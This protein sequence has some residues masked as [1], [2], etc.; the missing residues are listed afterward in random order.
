MSLSQALNKSQS[1]TNLIVDSLI[2][3]GVPI[4]G[5]G[6]QQVVGSPYINVITFGG[7]AT[8]DNGGVIEV[9]GGS[10]IVIGGSAQTPEINNIGVIGVNGC[11]GGVFLTSSDNTITITPDLV[12]NTVDITVPTPPIVVD[13]LNGCTGTVS[14]VSSDNT[15]TITP[16][17]GNG[18]IDLAAV[19][20]VVVDSLQ[21]LNG[22]VLLSSPLSTIAIGTNGQTIELDANFPAPITLTAGTGITVGT[23]PNYTVT[24]TA[25]AIVYTAGT[26]I[27][28]DVNNVIT[29]TAPGGG[30]SSYY[31]YRADNGAIPTT[32]HISWSNFGTQTSSTYIR[33]NHI[34]Q[35]GIDIDVFLNLIQQGNQLI[36][37][38]A[39]ASANYQTWL[40]S[41]TPIP[42]TGSGYAQFPITLVASGGSSNFANNHQLILAVVSSAPTP[43]IV[44]D[45]LNGCTG[46]VSLVS[47]DNTIT[48]TPDVLTSTVDL[49]F[50]PV[51]QATYYKSTAQTLTSGTTDI[52]FDLTGSWNNVGGCITH[53]DGTT[54]FTVARTGVYQLGFN[55][56]VNIGTGTWVA[57]SNKGI[58]IDITRSPITEVAVIRNTAAM[59]INSYTQSVSGTYY[60]VVGDVIN[61][62]LTNTFTNVGITPTQTL[63]FV[64][65]FDLNTF[66]SWTLIT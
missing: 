33:V 64:N 19:Q 8:I 50:P 26:G 66:F 61:L 46:T 57:G 18:T 40:V 62:S 23:A 59:A 13:S 55:A 30:S 12:A 39:N 1:G 24:N 41:G 48:I 56:F 4:T 25:P 2:V 35:N 14:L 20:P 49:T 7:V 27:D 15:I 44:V 34:D 11:N 52:T 42:N 63:G 53:V 32:G 45:S 16:D 6:V 21:S 37:Q 31:P 47:S 38:D 28:I 3:G 22:T 54:A 5:G 9:L 10:G 65:T 58:S 43:P 29:N 51:F 36:I 60:L 17:V